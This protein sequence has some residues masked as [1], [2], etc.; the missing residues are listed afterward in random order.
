MN[1]LLPFGDQ[2]IGVLENSAVGSGDKS[3][4]ADFVTLAKA[5]DTNIVSFPLVQDIRGQVGN[6]LRKPKGLVKA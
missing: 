6:R 2:G 1:S 5:L 4:G 3:V